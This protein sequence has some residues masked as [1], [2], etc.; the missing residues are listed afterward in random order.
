MQK[1]ILTWDRHLPGYRRTEWGVNNYDVNKHPFTKRAFK[2]KKWAFLSD[3]IRLDVLYQYGGVYMDTD[4]EVVKSFD[5]LLDDG[6][7]IG[8]ET[9]TSACPSVIGVIPKHWLI[10]EVLDEYNTLDGYLPIPRIFTKVLSKYTDI[11][12]SDKIQKFDD[13][14][15]YPREYFYPFLYDEKFTPKCVTAN[16]YAI[17]WWNNS[18]GDKH[19]KILSKLGLLV[20]AAKIKG[21]VRSILLKFR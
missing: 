13:V 7:F 4:I 9:N 17:H 8:M 18:W 5:P 2:D 14:T 1:C 20:P 11:P 15:I 19:K 10:K 21:S 3:F 12:T 16:T 6:L